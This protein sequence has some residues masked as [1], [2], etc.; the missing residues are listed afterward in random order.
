[1]THASVYNLTL[2]GRYQN[3]ELF[4]RPLPN[5]LES[6][7]NGE[8]MIKKFAISINGQISPNSQNDEH[9]SGEVIKM[10]NFS[11]PKF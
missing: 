8:E 5:S 9:L 11:N 2:Q 4:F 7:Q 10:A 3:G 1:M 6:Y